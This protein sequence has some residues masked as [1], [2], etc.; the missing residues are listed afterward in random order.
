MNQNDNFELELA[1][2]SLVD[3][4]LTDEQAESAK[5]GPETTA[6]TGTLSLSFSW[7]IAH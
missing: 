1:S 2:E 6:A 4:P 5:G 3:L 7:Y